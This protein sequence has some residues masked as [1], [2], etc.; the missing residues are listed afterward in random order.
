MKI[1][2][3]KQEFEHGGFRITL[4]KILIS[5]D[6]IE[7]VQIVNLEGLNEPD[8][9]NKFGN[10]VCVVLNGWAEAYVNGEVYKLKK[11]QGILFEPGEKH[12]IVKG[13]GLM[14]SISSED[15]D[16]GLD[17]VWE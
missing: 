9:I 7:S 11:N 8:H 12:K 10:V 2:D 13:E 1:F 4:P 15:Y 14:L 3:F 6:K 17:T 5:L 16:A